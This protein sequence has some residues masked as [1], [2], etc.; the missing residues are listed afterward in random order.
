M[1]NQHEKITFSDMILIV[2]PGLLA[3]HTISYQFVFFTQLPAIFVIFTNLILLFSFGAIFGRKFRF[4][5]PTI[6]KTTFLLLLLG[7]ITAVAAAFILSPNADDLSYYHRAIY[8]IHHL[9]E[10]FVKYDTAVNIPGI[11]GLTTPQ[12]VTSYEFLVAAISHILGFHP[13][14]GYHVI[15]PFFMA[16]YLVFIYYLLLKEIGFSQKAGIFGTIGIVAFFLFIDGNTIRSFGNVAFIR[17]W[18]GKTILWTLL[19]PLI[20]LLLLKYFHTK[21]PRFIFGLFLCS[22]SAV[23]LSNSGF[24]MPPILIGCLTLAYV[25]SHLFKCERKP[26]WK[27]FFMPLISF[28]Y[29]LSLGIVLKIAFISSSLNTSIYNKNWPG[30]WWENLFLVIG[31]MNGLIRNVLLCM[32]LIFAIK[33]ISERRMMAWYLILLPMVC[34]NPLAGKFWFAMILPASYWRLMYLAP[35]PLAFGA[36]LSF[37]SELPLS[38]SRLKVSLPA[39]ILC[40]IALGFTAYA[41]NSSPIGG[42]KVSVKLPWEYQLNKNLVKLE[43]T[44][45]LFLNHRVLL[46]DKEVSTALPLLNPTVSLTVPDYCQW[47]FSNAGMKNEGRQRQLAQTF[48]QG[49]FSNPEMYSTGKSALIYSLENIADALIVHKEMIPEILKEVTGIKGKWKIQYVGC[50]YAVFIKE[51]R[52]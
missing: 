37:L 22:I 49:G 14:L 8:Q 13:L 20:F 33:L 3:I 39:T 7:L 36:I 23:G 18:Q 29:P 10:P 16:L 38:K 9:G 1:K 17:L 50:G 43:K 32:A 34:F 40:F 35:I 19:L 27:D 2:P 52:L 21:L 46:A 41:F 15:F 5:I 11:Q 45:R 47:K 25:C 28:I 12:L 26:G 24:Y 31:D 44:A 48:I 6:N 51:A 4:T 30:I 42:K